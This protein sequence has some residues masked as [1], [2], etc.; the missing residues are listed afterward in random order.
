MPEKH[1]TALQH[2]TF[3]LFISP[4]ECSGHFFFSSSSPS[5]A[6]F[7]FFGFHSLVSLRPHSHGPLTLCRCDEQFLS[8]CFLPKPLSLEAASLPSSLSLLRLSPG[9][10][11][12]GWQFLSSERNASLFLR[13]ALILP[14]NPRG[15]PPPEPLLIGGTGRQVGASP[16][17]RAGRERTR[18]RRSP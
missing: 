15:A 13:S 17:S 11:D 16:G 2:K 4:D 8:C 14:T 10:R 9:A 1:I 18:A 6:L 7:V 3:I 5:F 12:P